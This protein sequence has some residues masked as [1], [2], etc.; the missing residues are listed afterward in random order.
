VE[1]PPLGNIKTGVIKLVETTYVS[2]FHL[3]VILAPAEFRE[4]DESYVDAAVD[5]IAAAGRI[6][7]GHIFR[8]DVVKTGGR[9]ATQRGPTNHP[10]QQKA[11]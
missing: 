5:Q 1:L 3:I 10:C 9:H 6:V 8:G 2:L 4:S 11:R 7:P